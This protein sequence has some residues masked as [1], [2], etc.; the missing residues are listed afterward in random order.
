VSYAEIALSGDEADFAAW[1]LQRSATFLIASAALEAIR[2]TIEN[3]ML[4]FI[5]RRHEGHRSAVCLE[6]RDGEVFGDLLESVGSREQ[7]ALG[8]NSRAGRNG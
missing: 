7:G 3:P 4:N 6:V 1:N 8:P 2:A 5:L